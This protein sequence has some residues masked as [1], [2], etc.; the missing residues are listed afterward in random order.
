MS[1]QIET[2]PERAGADAGWGGDL[3]CLPSEHDD[4]VVDLSSLRFAVPSFLL[5]LRSFID[6]HCIQG[7][8][9]EVLMPDN[10]DVN[11]YLM[12]MRLGRDLPR[13]ATLTD[14]L[15]VQE[16]D[17]GSVL[18]PLT[19]LASLP[20]VDQLDYDL[21]G[22][23]S[24]HFSQGNMPQLA[25]TFHQA[26]AELCGN[27]AEHGGDSR[28]GAYIA[29]Q[30]YQNSRCSLAISDLGI[31]VPT[32]LR[33]RYASWSDEHA[34]EKVTEPGVSG[35][36]DDPHRGYGLAYVLEAA[37]R[38]ALRSATVQIRSGSAMATAQVVGNRT[39][40]Q[41]Q[42]RSGDLPGTWL[43]VELRTT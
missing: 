12:R 2:V 16:H 15:H 34:L 9:V 31:G 3:H 7:T 29:A 30:R 43:A 5:R 18:I 35:V 33:Q 19:R 8:S 17:R 10:P 26:V 1:Y 13:Q 37:E 42:S 25:K 27:A 14:A 40:R 4:I 11:H 39:T 22:L 32:H 36:V 20:D 28:I 24:A 21:Q 38:S 23:M 6:W 41:A